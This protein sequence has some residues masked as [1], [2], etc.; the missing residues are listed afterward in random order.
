MRV[1][2][3]LLL[4]GLAFASQAGAAE[5]TAVSRVDAVTVFPAGAEVTR[6]AKVRLEPGEHAVVFP[7]LPA[8]AVQNSIRV[9]GRATGSLEIGSVD[10]RRLSV[11]RLDPEAAASERRRLEDEI[12]RLQDE[13]GVLDGQ[14]AAAEAQKKLLEGLTELPSRPPAPGPDGTGPREDWGQLLGLLATGMTQAQRALVETQIK[15][16][17]LDRRIEDLKKKLAALAPAREERTEV[18]I[19]VSVAAP[20]E[21][22]LAVRYQVPGASWA[23]L[24]DAR[25]AT[26]SKTASPKLELARRASIT[27]RSGESWTEAA[28][29]LSTT[30]PGSGAAAPELS[31]ATVDFEPERKIVAAP[32]PTARS[33]SEPESAAG[34]ADEDRST[35]LKAA[36]RQEAA[37]RPAEIAQAPFQAVFAIP[38]RVSVAGT[39]EAKRVYLQQDAIEPALAVRTVPKVDAKAFLYAKL[40]LPKGSPLL[41]GPV[42]LFRDGTFVGTGRLPLLVAGEEHELGFGA[43]D[44]V[45]VKHAIAE[46]KRGETGL[47]SSSRIDQRNYRITVK[48]LHE[49]PIPLTVIDQVPVALNQDIKVELTGRTAP[50]R[51]D[52]DDKRGVVAWETKLEPDEERV[53]EFGYRV[54]WPGGRNIVY[55]R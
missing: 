42:S 39:G 7:D 44:A 10:S 28:I 45:R 52:L 55:G 8:G 20:V 22:D 33:A 30:R 41:P 26:G 40:A 50:T 47:I 9:E 24:Y 4:L 21:A 18:K 29:Q 37:E 13:R 12:E 5:V 15:T 35:R 2:S 49:R 31:V 3:L 53:I 43:D 51:R 34:L 14:V 54:T 19:L 23:P 27:Q 17:E 25:L 36:P 38:G 11:P 1:A 16:R 32:A 46:E 6:L 48:N